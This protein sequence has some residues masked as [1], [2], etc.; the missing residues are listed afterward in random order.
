MS[1]DLSADLSAL[2]AALLL[3]ALLAVGL[4]AAAL[5]RTRRTAAAHTLSLR[6]ELERLR[7]SS[8]ELE[9]TSYTDALTGVWNYRYLQL[10][11]DREIARSARQPRPD[12][13]DRLALLLLEI[14]G[15]DEIRREHGHQRGGA[16]LRDLAQRLAMEVR[17]ADVFGRYGGEEFLILLPDTDAAGAEHVAERLRWTVR[18]HPLALPSVPVLPVPDAGAASAVGGSAE[19]GAAAPVNGLSAA[20]GISVLPRDGGHAALL[21]RAADRALAAARTPAAP[22]APAVSTAPPAPAATPVDTAADQP[23]GH[24]KV[25]ETSTSQPVYALLAQGCDLTAK[26]REEA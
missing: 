3:A 16:V 23:Q 15:F 25:L 13:Q 8:A 1:M 17:E 14:E 19:E 2:L 24:V 26:E 5:R 6:Q 11:L 10:S 4:T 18:R 21:L 12:G 22:A 7:R 9:R 20:I